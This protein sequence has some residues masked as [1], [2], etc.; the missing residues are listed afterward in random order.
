MRD[1]LF[2]GSQLFSSSHCSLKIAL[3]VRYSLFFDLVFSWR[4]INSFW[5]G[6][7]SRFS[8]SSEP[9][10]FIARHY[11]QL[12]RDIIYILYDCIK[13]EFTDSQFRESK[14]FAKR[15]TKIRRF[16]IVFAW[17][18]DHNRLLIRWWRLVEILSFH[19]LSIINPYASNNETHVPRFF[20]MQLFGN[21]KRCAI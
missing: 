3:M 1:I 11:F 12:C 5:K 14:Y 13:L 6:I 2:S 4:D 20:S 19:S 21:T 15:I 10:H 17:N 18:Q 8:R 9:Q 7:N 16:F